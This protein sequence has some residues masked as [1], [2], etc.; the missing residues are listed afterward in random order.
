VLTDRAPGADDVRIDFDIHAQFSSNAR[1]DI[2][3]P[4]RSVTVGPAARASELENDAACGATGLEL[5]NWKIRHS[6]GRG[7]CLFGGR[8]LLCRWPRCVL[9]AICPA[10]D[11]QRY[12]FCRFDEARKCVRECTI[13]ILSCVLIAEH[14][15]WACVAKLRH[16]PLR[17]APSSSSFVVAPWVPMSHRH[18]EG[19]GGGAVWPSYRS[20]RRVPGSLQRFGRKGT[21]GR[22]C[23]LPPRNRTT[24]TQL[25]G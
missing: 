12:D 11:S 16:Q 25:L 18:D 23:G 21:A 8:V 22:A 14:G 24:V 2:P 1:T 17:P 19:H 3:E 6:A 13:T 5:D 7:I 15:P 9:G 20:T 4:L 10:Q